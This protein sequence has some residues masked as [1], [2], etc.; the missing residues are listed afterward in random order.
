MAYGAELTGAVQ[1]GGV[2]GA[3][4]TNPQGDVFG[5]GT[6]G[7]WMLIEWIIA[8]IWLLIVWRVIDSY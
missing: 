2:F 7:R 1:A 6:V 3:S 8:T 4:D 5:P